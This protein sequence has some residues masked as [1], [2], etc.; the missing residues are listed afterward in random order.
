L[1]Q[2]TRPDPS[3][4]LARP[5]LAEQALEGVVRAA[6]YRDT[7]PMQAAAPAT[8]IRAAGST[9]AARLD[10]LLFGEIFDVLEV[11]GGHAW[12]RA[13]RTGV[14]GH[15]DVSALS[16]EIILPT[17]RVRAV[18]AQSDIGSLPLNALVTLEADGQAAVRAGAVVAADLAPIGEFETDAAAVAE[19]L[20]DTPYVQ[21][22]RDASGIDAA[23]LVQQALAATGQGGERALAYRAR[24][25]RIVDGPP[26]R[27]DVAIWGGHA[28]LAVSQDQLIHASASVGCVVVE[29]LATVIDRQGGQ[30]LWIRG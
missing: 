28:A 30:P 9:K 23:G 3:S 29:S 11:A 20:T 25:T 7:Q 2:S 22:G 1:P 13:R 15:V 16:D 5:D 12:G 8:A 6:A 4:R 19:A 17:H 14:V 24:V 26:R 18:E 27:G 21:G 10:V